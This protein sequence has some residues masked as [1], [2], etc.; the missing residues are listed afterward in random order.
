MKAGSHQP[1]CFVEI[2]L[3]LSVLVAAAELDAAS[4]QA[5]DVLARGHNAG[6]LIGDV[7]LHARLRINAQFTT[8]VDGGSQAS[9]ILASIFVLGIIL[10][11]V[12]VVFRAVATEALGSDLELAGAIAKGEEAEDAE[13]EAD[14][15]SRDRLDGANIN[16]LG[17]V[18]QP[19][20]EV[21]SGDGHL[22]EFLAIP[23]AGHG[24]RQ[25]GIFNIAVAPWKQ[26]LASSLVGVCWAR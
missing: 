9:I 8:L 23:G 18:T 2:L 26:M 7:V 11:V 10:W 19:V 16:S 25:E 22:V 13:E 21:G 24:E 1:E 20:A 6:P 17:V 15:L 14:G 4:E 12:D 5:A 3:V